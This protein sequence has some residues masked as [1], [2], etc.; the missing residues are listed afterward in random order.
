MS[1]RTSLSLLAAASLA[2]STGCGV[3]AGDLAARYWATGGVSPGNNFD[4]FLGTSLVCLG[5]TADLGSL[6]A[7]SPVF[8]VEGEVVSADMTAP[9]EGFDNLVPCWTAPQTALVLRDADGAT[10]T[11]GFGWLSGDGYDMTPWPALDAGDRVELVLRADR[12]PGSQ[13]AG[14]ALSQ[15]GRLLYALESGR[16]G[17]GLQPGDIAGLETRTLDPVGTYATDCGERASLAQE[18]ASDGDTL[19]MY[20]GEDDAVQVGQDQLTTCSIDAWELVDGGC[21]DQEI[22]TESSWVMFR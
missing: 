15:Q 13:A 18:F 8:R 4:S 9:T 17:Q 3:V 19:V 1:L 5:T 7:A 11:V 20:A 12:S 16:G 22:T 21:D 6:G 14:M 10:W 2:L